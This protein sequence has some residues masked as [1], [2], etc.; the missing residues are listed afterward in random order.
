MLTIIDCV[1]F[2]LQYSLE[3][4]QMNLEGICDSQICTTEVP[5]NDFSQDKRYFPF[6]R[7]LQLITA[8]K[9][10]LILYQGLSE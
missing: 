5:A 2:W 9:S 7:T 10:P 4:S 3:N 6:K 8:G 1:V